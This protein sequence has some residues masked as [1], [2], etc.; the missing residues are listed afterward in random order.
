MIRHSTI[1]QSRLLLPKLFL[2][3]KALEPEARPSEVS[4][5]ADR[6][7]KNGLKEQLFAMSTRFTAKNMNWRK[8]SLVSRLMGWPK[9][10]EDLGTCLMLLFLGKTT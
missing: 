6:K 2:P 5:I 4:L 8:N 10:Q 3:F 1:H 9:D 7:L